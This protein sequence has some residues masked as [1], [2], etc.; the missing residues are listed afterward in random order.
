MKKSNCNSYHSISVLGKLYDISKYLLSH[1]AYQSFSLDGKM[2][3]KKALLNKINNN[4]L[5]SEKEVENNKSMELEKVTKNNIFLNEKIEEN[6]NV[7]NETLTI[8]RR[9]SNKSCT[10]STTNKDNHKNNNKTKNTND[11]NDIDK[12]D[13]NSNYNNDNN[14]DDEQDRMNSDM[15]GCDVLSY[16]DHDSYHTETETETETETQTETRTQSHEQTQTHKQTQSNFSSYS[17]LETLAIS[18]IRLDTDLHTSGSSDYLQ[19]ALRIHDKYV[20]KSDK[21]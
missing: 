10:N 3:E 19:L 16:A 12:N 21:L 15:Y 14:N 5:Y 7:R 18:G 8:A 11:E 20:L 1:L 4:I 9:N 6:E 2:K 13:S 17:P